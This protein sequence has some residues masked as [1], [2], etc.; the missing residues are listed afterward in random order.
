MASFRFTVFDVIETLASSLRALDSMNGVDIFTAHPGEYLP[1]TDAVTFFGSEHK[2][3]AADLG[4]GDTDRYN[5]Y[6]STY[7]LQEGTTGDVAKAVR[8]RAKELLTQLAG[9]VASDRS[10]G[11]LVMYADIATAETDQGVDSDHRWCEIKF[12]LQCWAQA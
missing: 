10:V 3:V 12:E 9:V 6:G 8:D 7:S 5:V 1:F 4:G 2:R 11:G